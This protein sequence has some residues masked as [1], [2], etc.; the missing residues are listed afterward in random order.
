VKPDSE[1]WPQVQR[2]LEGSKGFGTNSVEQMA[3]PTSHQL[4]PE[5]VSKMNA[6][7]ERYRWARAE[8][9]P[10]CNEPR[11]TTGDVT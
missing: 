11:P 9:M 1:S 10:R 2:K 6:R 8:P 7:I 4:L 3:Y 5:K